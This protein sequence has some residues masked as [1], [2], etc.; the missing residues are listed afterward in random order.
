MK[1]E[2][3][4][5][6][7]EAGGGGRHGRG[8][9]GQA[10]GGK[11]WMKI[12]LSPRPWGH[13][14]CHRRPT[15]T[16]APT[17]NGGVGKGGGQSASQLSVLSLVCL[18][19]SCSPWPLSEGTCFRLSVYSHSVHLPASARRCLWRD[20]PWPLNLPCARWP[21][22]GGCWCLIVF[23]CSRPSRS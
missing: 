10:V 11:R 9:V 3:D 13:R 8:C 19:S 2:R 23:G 5:K 20:R 18:S 12:G 14:R 15:R 6:R 22:E 4:G 21:G 16:R 17:Q 1:L 7:S